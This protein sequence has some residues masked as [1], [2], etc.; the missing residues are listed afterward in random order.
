[1]T[2]TYE[3]IIIHTKNKYP[4]LL[5]DAFEEMRLRLPE[6]CVVITDENLM[7]YYS[8][9]LKPYRCIVLKTGEENKQWESLCYIY[10]ELMRFNAGRDTFLLAFGGGMVLD[11]AGFAASTYKRGCSFGFVATSLL[12]MADASVGGKNGFNFGGIKNLIGVF[13]QPDF[14]I[15]DASILDTLPNQEFKSGLCEIIKYG[16]I[17]DKNL[18]EY[19]IQNS[20]SI[21]LRNAE[22]MNYLI[23]ASVQIKAGYVIDDEYDYGKRQHLN[24]GH[25]FGHAIEMCTALSHGLAVACGMYIA[26]KIAIKMGICHPQFEEKLLQVFSIFDI[27]VDCPISSEII[28]AMKNDKKNTGDTIR[29]VLPRNIGDTMLYDFNSDD[30]AKLIGQ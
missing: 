20:N 1:M 30:L 10:S 5:C 19:V 23:E 4:V 3:E 16:F 18:L 29:M 27:S 24:F 22:V 13:N 9:S 7:T 11:M 8:G 28:D 15:C 17:A 6:N 21:V 12:A 14:V 25:S 26:T 2:H